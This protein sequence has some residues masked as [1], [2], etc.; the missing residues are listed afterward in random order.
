MDWID[1][2]DGDGD[3][4]LFRG[5]FLRHSASRDGAGMHIFRRARAYITV[6]GHGHEAQRATTRPRRRLSQQLVP[7][8][9][10]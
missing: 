1:F 6:G 4:G 5:T 10:L 7:S 3:G 8:I 2:D 9:S